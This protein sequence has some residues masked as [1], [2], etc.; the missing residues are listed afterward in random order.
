[1]QYRRAMTSASWQPDPTGRNQFRWWDGASWTDH[2]SNNGAASVDP[3]QPPAAPQVQAPV[4]AP[5]APAAAPA[6][7]PTMVNPAAGAPF[8]ATATAGPAKSGPTWWKIAL[9]VL[10]VLAVGAVL[11]V[12]IGGDDGSSN[13]LGVTE[14]ELKNNDEITTLKFDLKKGDVIR[15]RVEAENDQPRVAVIADDATTT[16]YEDLILGLFSDSEFSDFVTDT[17]DLFTDVDSVFS[18]AD[19]SVLGSDK[20]NSALAEFGEFDENNV[21]ADFFPALADGTYTVVI[22]SGGDSELGKVRIIVEQRDKGIPAKALD[23]FTALDTFFSDTSD[24]FF[25][26]DAFYSDSDEFTPK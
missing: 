10:A 25:S 1:M 24:S 21:A 23:D 11:F 9:P 20:R 18:D 4:A 3:L 22:G 15:I 12:V 19:L 16:K 26:D 8:T 7:A 2:V 5:V 13:P 6:P 17:S 14:T